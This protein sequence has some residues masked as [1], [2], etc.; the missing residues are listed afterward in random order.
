MKTAKL[1]INGKEIEVQ[2]S[3]EQIQELTKSKKVTGFERAEFGNTY[4][5]KRDGD[6]CSCIEHRLLNDDYNYNCSNYYTDEILAQWCRRSDNLTHK[7]R[8][9]AAEHNTKPID[10]NNPTI[11]RR[12]CVL[13]DPATHGFDIRPLNRLLHTG[14]VYF[15][16]KEIAEAAIKEFGDEI[17]WLAENRSKWF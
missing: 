12:W 11:I 4:W 16:D 10:W 6:I 8:R 1:I 15:S 17:K 14:E 3:D 2:I 7:M 9:W 5:L 13:Y